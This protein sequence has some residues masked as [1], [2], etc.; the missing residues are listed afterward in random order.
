M[1]VGYGFLPCL[2]SAIH[3]LYLLHYISSNV[4]VIHLQN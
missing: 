3:F 2:Y 4:F 1:N